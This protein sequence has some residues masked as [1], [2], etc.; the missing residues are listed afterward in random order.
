MAIEIAIKTITAK[1]FTI[2]ITHCQGV[3]IQ[4]CVKDEYNGTA[5]AELGNNAIRTI[6]NIGKESNAI[7]CAVLVFIIVILKHVQKYI[8][9]LQ[10]RNQNI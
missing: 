10:K 6:I 5:L 7:N 2:Y 3:L 4:S 9:N 8:L 1:I